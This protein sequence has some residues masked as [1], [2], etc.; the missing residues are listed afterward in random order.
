MRQGTF[1]EDLYYRLNVLP[2]NLPALSERPEDVPPLAMHFIEKVCREE[3]IPIKYA[4]PDLLARLTRHSWPGNVRQLE[5]AVEM[6]V[7]LSGDRQELSA[8]DFPLPSR[9]T[10]RSLSGDQP[11]FIAVPDHGLDFEQTVGSIEKQLL[12]QA[13][14][15]TNGNKKAAAEMLRLK[16]TTL[17]AKLKILSAAAAAAQ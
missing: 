3:A 16:R 9:I 17:S 12:E 5:N 6:A 10:A 2:I 13:L 4:S 14:Q 1:R 7:A 8:G 11:P 15:K